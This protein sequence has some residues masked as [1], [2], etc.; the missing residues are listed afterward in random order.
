MEFMENN[1]IK[2]NFTISNDNNFISKIYNTT[3]AQKKLLNEMAHRV[4]GKI[5]KALIRKIDKLS[6]EHPNLPQLRNYLT[7][8]YKEIG[9]YDKAVKIN[10]ELMKDFPHYLHARLNAANFCFFKGQP[11]EALEYLGNNLDIKEMYPE[12]DE[13]HF[14]EVQSFYYTTVL[15]A[16]AKEDLAL[17]ENRFEFYK[18]LDQ[19]NPRIEKLE[20]QILN[21][22]YSLLVKRR[23]NLKEVF[24]DFN[25]RP[26][27][28]IQN[29]QLPKFHHQEIW[30]LYEVGFDNTVDSIKELLQL[31]RKTLVEDLELVL[32]DAV[33]RYVELS[34]EG[35]DIKKHTFL[36]HA[37]F[38]LRELNSEESLSKIKE[39]LSFDKEMIEFYFGDDLCEIVWLVLFDLGKN[40]LSEL[41]EYLYRSEV[42]TFTKTEFAAALVQLAIHYPEKKQ[43]IIQILKR[44]FEY[45]LDDTIEKRPIDPIFLGIA[46]SDLVYFSIDDVVPLI[47][48]LFDKGYVDLDIMGDWKEFEVIYNEKSDVKEEIGR[49]IKTIGEVYNLSYHDWE[50]EDDYDSSDFDTEKYIKEVLAPKQEP[51]NS[52][53]IGRNDLC[54]CGSGKKYKKCCGK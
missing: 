9:Q 36:L 45:L 12:R 25:G 51:F 49:E 7:V 22:R 43:E 6:K 28:E 13:F 16:I 29:V 37:L 50:E 38:L 11:E 35:W 32:V 18:S 14:S 19:E 39:V 23:E 46:I 53:K 47:K 3:P 15:Y 17:V 8:A 1:K 42:H 48:E 41:E 2:S 31:P 27:P 44:L 20:N 26:I 5:D 21:L 54:I 34:E 52:T 40:Q 10:E 4:Q 30:R 33:N 24:G